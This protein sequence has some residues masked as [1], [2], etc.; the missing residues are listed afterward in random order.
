MK[1][2]KFNE[3][4]CPECKEKV[5]IKKNGHGRCKCGAH[6]KYLNEK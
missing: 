3:V 2:T 4:N 1:T 6:V 5:K